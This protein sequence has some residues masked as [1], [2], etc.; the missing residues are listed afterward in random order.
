M[1]LFAIALAPIVIIAFYLYYRD[2]YEKE[3][4]WWLVVA[5]IAGGII[6]LPVIYIE[7]ILAIPGYYMT[8]YFQAAWDAF[9]VAAFTEELFKFAALMIIFWN[10]RHFN[11]KFD[12][13]VYASFVSLGFAAIEN[14]LYV[15][16]GGYQVGLTRAFTAVPAHAL[17]GIIMG[18]RVGLAKFYPEERRKQLTMA[19]L[20]PML[21]HGTYDFILMSGHEYL[22]FVFVPFLVFL[23]IYGFKRLKNLSDRSIYR[24]ISPGK[25][26]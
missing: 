13:I 10:N 3:P 4:F 7:R 6:T 19:L 15:I 12:G 20:M 11:E 17:F 24:W 2:K 5:L 26:G 16:N 9:V 22:I 21:F 18:Y 25:S 8:R 23:W 14:L 1:G